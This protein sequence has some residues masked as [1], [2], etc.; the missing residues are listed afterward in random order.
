MGYVSWLTFTGVGFTFYGMESARVTSEILIRIAQEAR[1]VTARFG[2]VCVVAVLVLTGL[3]LHVAESGAADIIWKL[4]LKYSS[5]PIFSSTTGEGVELVLPR[6]TLSGGD[7]GAQTLVDALENT[8]LLIPRAPSPLEI[9]ITLNISG[10]SFEQA[11]QK[12]AFLNMSVTTLVN[13]RVEDPYRFPTGSP[14]TVIIPPEGL[15][16]LLD[17]CGFSRSDDIVLAFDNNGS[18]TKDGI[19]TRNYTSGLTAEIGHLSTIV[20]STTNALGLS[21]NVR[22]KNWDYIK[23]LFK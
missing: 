21:P 17:R 14:M 5:T 8:K 7:A 22:L 4:Y 3:C 13:G 6:I 20:G 16:V 23:L 1:R 19:V 11:H 15:G 9:R 10:A 18:F 2:T 12:K